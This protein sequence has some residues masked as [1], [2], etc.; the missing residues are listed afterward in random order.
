MRV[1]L[2]VGALRVVLG[3][4]L[5]EHVVVFLH[6]IVDHL[7]N[8]RFLFRGASLAGVQQGVGD[9]FLEDVAFFRALALVQ[10]AVDVALEETVVVE[11]GVDVDVVVLA[12]VVLNGEGGSHH[13]EEDK[14]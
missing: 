5:L 4:Q 7:L 6:Q 3:R 14:N 12:G 8:G 13:E 1:V 10:Q 9:D 11:D 2:L